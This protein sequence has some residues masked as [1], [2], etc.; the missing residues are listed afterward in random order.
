MIY[1]IYSLLHFVIY[2]CTKHETNSNI[3]ASWWTYR[4]QTDL[5]FNIQYCFQFLLKK[6]KKYSNGKNES[7]KYFNG[8]KRES[9]KYSNGK[10][11]EIEAKKK[12]RKKLW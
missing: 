11:H 1:S 9:K 8:K 6:V 5:R 12:L 10:K 2:I 4:I 3:F 7:K